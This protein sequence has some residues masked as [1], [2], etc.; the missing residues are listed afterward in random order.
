MPKIKPA[1]LL[2][3][4]SI[5]ILLAGCSPG[6]PQYLAGNLNGRNHTSAA[7]NYFTVNGYGGPN[8]APYGS[9]GGYCCVVLPRQWQ[10]GL[11]FQVEWETDPD[12]YAK[13]QRKTSGYGYV[14]EAYALHKANYKKHVVTVEIPRY[15]T[16]TLCS[17]K[18]HFLPCHTIK[19][20]TAC[21]AYGQPGY[22]IK[23]PKII[24]E[25]AVCPQ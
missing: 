17:L 10:P 3:M 14:E 15:D 12:P 20:T 23:E 1:H 6:T 7:I 16:E 11:A 8:I 19:A 18:I 21:P 5:A 25:P 22:P 2:L 13:I 4:C 9:G 24:K